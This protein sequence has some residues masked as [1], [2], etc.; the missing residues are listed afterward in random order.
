M[1]LGAIV[2]VAAAAIYFGVQPAS[3]GFTGPHV[4][5]YYK[6]ATFKK[7]VGSK[8]VGCCGAVIDWGVVTPY[9][10][11]Q[12]LYCPDVVCPIPT[13]TIRA[14]AAWTTEIRAGAAHP[15]VS[16]SAPSRSRKL[17]L[18]RIE[19][20]PRLADVAELGAVDLRELAH[21]ARARRPFDR[22]AVAA[23]SR[24]LRPVAFEGPGVDDLAAALGH[25]TDPQEIEGR[26]RGAA[27]D[28]LAGL[29]RE[30]PARHVERRFAGWD[31]A[32]GDAPRS[33]VL[34]SEPRAARVHEEDLEHRGSPAEHQEPGT[35]P[36]STHGRSVG[37]RASS[38][39]GGGPW[40][41]RFDASTTTT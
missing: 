28:R 33:G 13:E 27:L 41:S 36:L 25:R 20:A 16:S 31:L 5:S 35:R 38:G 3:A 17:R 10:K 22:E 40:G 8:G 11:C 6:D 24:P 30:L 29:F 39:D 15:I 12:Q 7:V 2:L 32:L 18:C 4:C 19:P 34:A 9:K 14:A 1:V 26:P 37:Y 21:P 23:R